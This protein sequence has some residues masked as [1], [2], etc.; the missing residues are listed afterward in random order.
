ML[1]PTTS[2]IFW[3]TRDADPEHAIEEER[4]F[5]CAGSYH[6]PNF[7]LFIVFAILCLLIYVNPVGT[8]FLVVVVGASMLLFNI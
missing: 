8:A 6:S 3:R 4:C 5:P 7:E 2:F 1:M